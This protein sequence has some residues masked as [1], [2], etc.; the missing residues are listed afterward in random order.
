MLKGSLLKRFNK[1]EEGYKQQFYV[2]KAEVH[3]SPSQFI[4]R[5]NSYLE[6]WIEL[7][8]VEKSYEGLTTLIV[9][10][11]Y[12]S[13]CT[14]DLEVFLR[15]RAVTDLKDLAKIAEQYMD[16]NRS[17][18]SVGS[19]SLYKATEN[20]GE[21]RKWINKTSV[22]KGTIVKKCYICEKSNH[23]AKNCYHRQKTGA[24]YT[25]EQ[26]KWNNNYQNSSPRNEKTEQ[27]KGSY[28]QKENGQVRKLKCKSHGKALC[29]D[30]FVLETHE[31]SAVLQC[32]CSIPVI[33]DA[34]STE[35][36]MRMPVTEG[37]LNGKKV[38]VLRD[39]GCST[40]VVRRSLIEDSLLT[41]A[42]TMCVLIDGT[43]RRTP[44]A[45]V[46]IDTK[47][48]KGQLEAVCMRNPLY[49]LIIGNVKGMNDEYID[50]V[51]EEEE[52]QAVLTRQGKIKEGMKISP[53]NV[54]KQ[55]TSL[56][57]KTDIMRLQKEDESLKVF[58][59]KIGVIEETNGKDIQFIEKAG[60]LYRTC[61]VFDRTVITQLVVPK[62][63]RQE[64]IKL[65]HDSIMSGHQG[66]RR[67]RD[68][69]FPRFWFPGLTAEVTRFCKSCD[70]CQRTI[71]KGRVT[72]VPLGRMPLIETPFE[73]VAIDLVGPIVPASE[74]GN[75][76]LLT[77]V[78][79][80][81]RQ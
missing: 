37:Y 25:Q 81:T 28:K 34:C 9:R 20:K 42:E 47:F 67:T 73:R 31:C 54:A 53:L 19:K 7:A 2:S 8:E 56:V 35:R 46:N 18:G 48:L 38:T 13:T 74:R 77:V 43:I 55:M 72:K 68:R 40:I 45:R 61:L 36:R 33:A 3:E 59:D 4:T 6:R 21:D 71:S 76:Y 10:E 27:E 11:Q 23:L 41:G 5:I 24:M 58:F 39:S 30:C 44:V 66:I 63:L 26:T 17:K 57:S 49:D 70:V 79:Y 80:A 60:L 78:D 32:G 14:K 52:V 1:T 22:D 15:E 64:V 75:R 29:P 62:S 65:A 69:I 12:L 50:G 51:S 16:A